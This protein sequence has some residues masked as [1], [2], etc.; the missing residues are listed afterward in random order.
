M[1][2]E[3]ERQREEDAVE[4]ETLEAL[5]SALKDVCPSSSLIEVH[6]LT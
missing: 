1:A 2:E 4:R 3:H 5:A 6:R